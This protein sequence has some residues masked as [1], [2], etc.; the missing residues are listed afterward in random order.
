M[1][2]QLTYNLAR[3]TSNIAA[4]AELRSDLP[5]V[6]KLQQ[7]SGWGGLRD[8]IYQPVI[9]KQLKS[10]VSDTDIKAIKETVKTAYY[11]PERL[12]N[13]IYQKLQSMQFLPKRILEPSAGHGVFIK[14]IPDSW[15]QQATVTAVEMDSISCKLLKTLYPN[16]TVCHGRFEE[17][18]SAERFD[19]VVG[20]PPYGQIEFKDELNPDLAVCSIHHYFVGKCMRLLNEGGILAMVLP[21]YFLDA[22]EKHLR[23]I[24][25]KEGGSLLKAYRLPDDLFDDAK[26]T[27]DLVFLQKKSGDESWI[28]TRPF[29]EDGKR[30]Y[31]N[32]YF[33]QHPK[34]VLGNIEFIKAYGRN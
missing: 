6:A 14:A 26:V 11:T 16:I 33:F 4:L 10:L 32:T 29:I 8:A 7:Y 31:M 34:Q 27:V 24:I 2:N 12:V 5:D 18:N 28:K 17:F 13:F 25:G 15:Q 21:R 1:E 20:N 22:P 23:H 19:L 3:A 30:A 9:Y